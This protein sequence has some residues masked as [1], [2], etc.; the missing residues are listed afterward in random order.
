MA[1]AEPLEFELA[2]MT[3][4]SKFAFIVMESLQ[5]SIAVP[6]TVERREFRRESLFLDRVEVS[7]NI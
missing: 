1:V 3:G 6:L 5:R 4:G 2:A 7:D